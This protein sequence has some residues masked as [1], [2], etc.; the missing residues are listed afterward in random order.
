VF[1]LIFSK[2]KKKLRIR[3][4]AQKTSRNGPN[5]A[6]NTRLP[7]CPLPNVFVAIDPWDPDALILEEEYESH[8]VIW[9]VQFNPTSYITPRVLL[10]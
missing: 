3:F 8:I 7:H 6:L 1:G 2:P 9:T 5:M 4:E 10:K